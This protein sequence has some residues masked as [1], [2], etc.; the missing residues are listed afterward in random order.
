MSRPPP[1]FKPSGKLLKLLQPLKSNSP[2]TSKSAGILSKPIQPVSCNRP[3]TFKPAGKLFSRIQWSRFRLPT[4]L[5]LIIRCSV[6]LSLLSSTN[7]LSE[8]TP[9]WLSSINSVK[10]ASDTVFQ[11]SYSFGPPII[12]PATFRS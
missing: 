10:S 6:A 5:Y 2:S 11:F 9:I 1:I 8:T 3:S 4:P 7:S 12:R